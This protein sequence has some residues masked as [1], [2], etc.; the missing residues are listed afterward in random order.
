MGERLFVRW[1]IDVPILFATGVAGAVLVRR[2]R[3]LWRSLLAAQI[4]LVV[5][6]ALQRGPDAV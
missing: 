3:W 5:V 6:L 1:T 2:E 4:T